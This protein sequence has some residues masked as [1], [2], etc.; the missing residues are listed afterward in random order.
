MNFIL[1]FIRNPIRC[2]AVRRF[3]LNKTIPL[4]ERKGYKKAMRELEMTLNIPDE[5]SVFQ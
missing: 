5:V 1:H 2:N 4:L 3:E